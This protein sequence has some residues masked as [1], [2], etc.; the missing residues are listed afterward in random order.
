MVYGSLI[1][2]VVSLFLSVGVVEVFA[3]DQGLNEVLSRVMFVVHNS[4]GS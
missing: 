2:I 3:L 4:N 1:V